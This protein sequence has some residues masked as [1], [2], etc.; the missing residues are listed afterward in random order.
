MIKQA[1]VNI[2]HIGPHVANGHYHLLDPNNEI[3]LPQVWEVAVQPGWDIVMQLW[4]L[5]E[6]TKD[7]NTSV[8]PGYAA[9][10]KSYPERRTNPA[11]SRPKSDSHQVTRK[12]NR[13]SAS[14]HSAAVI[15][16]DHLPY[17][18]Q[19]RRLFR[20][21]MTYTDSIWGGVHGRIPELLPYSI[22]PD[23]GPP[24]KSDLSAFRK[25]NDIRVEEE[26]AY[27]S[28][29][30]DQ[31]Q[32]EGKSVERQKEKQAEQFLPKPTDAENF[33]EEERE[34]ARKKMPTIMRARAYSLA[35]EEA[36]EGIHEPVRTY[37]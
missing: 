3:I 30:L 21:N 23:P 32:R 14:R 33:Q 5:P 24:H 36:L 19:E 27:Q 35:A 16:S 11:S 17:T 8:S 26:D 34:E 1:F 12:S 29:E 2:E 25:Q 18:S 4:P 37:T 31:I 10:R 22:D 9:P 13:L 28:R 6:P 7:G 20:S 15:G